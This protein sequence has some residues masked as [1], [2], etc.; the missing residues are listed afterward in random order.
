MLRF[1]FSVEHIW[2]PNSP[3]LSECN[4]CSWFCLQVVD[5]IASMIQ[6]ACV[7]LDQATDQR[8]GSPI[9]SQT[10]SMGMGLVATVL[11]GPK[12]LTTEHSA[13]PPHVHNVHP[14]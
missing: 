9:E 3:F 6:R 7:C 2:A 12:V 13:H 10:L 11:S 4:M 8:L 1:S 14:E 5:F